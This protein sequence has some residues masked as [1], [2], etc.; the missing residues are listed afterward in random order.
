L[1]DDLHLA[2]QGDH[3][4]VAAYFFFNPAVIPAEKVFRTW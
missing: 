3:L 2:V 4:Q 1:G